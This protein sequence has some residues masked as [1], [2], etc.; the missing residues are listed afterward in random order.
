MESV[1]RLVEQ[2]VQLVVI[3]LK[4]TAA[5]VNTL[6]IALYVFDFVKQVAQ[7]VDQDTLVTFHLGWWSA[8]LAQVH[9]VEVVTFLV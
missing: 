2:I 1:R 3:D 5:H 7:G 9:V 8:E 4:V 6:A